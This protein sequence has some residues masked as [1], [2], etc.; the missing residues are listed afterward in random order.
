MPAFGAANFEVHAGAQDEKPVVPTRMRLFHL[1]NITGPYI[2][3]AASLP[4]TL[5]YHKFV[6]ARNYRG[7]PAFLLRAAFCL[8]IGMSGQS[9]P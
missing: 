7:I 1:K 2:H 4:E 5:L 3:A 9:L 6:Q 8:F